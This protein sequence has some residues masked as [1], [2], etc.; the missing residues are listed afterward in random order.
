MSGVLDSH[1]EPGRGDGVAA[2]RLHDTFEQRME[3]RRVKETDP[4][5]LK[6]IWRWWDWAVRRARTLECING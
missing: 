5:A 3:A 1:R 2:K 6:L 4:E